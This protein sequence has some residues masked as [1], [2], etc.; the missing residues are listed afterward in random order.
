MSK[1]VKPTSES[2]INHAKENDHVKENDHM[3]ESDRSLKEKLQDLE[4]YIA[5]DGFTSSV[6]SKLPAYSSARVKP[7]SYQIWLPLFAS[8]IGSAFAAGNLFF[9]S[10]LSSLYSNAL[11]AIGLPFVKWSNVFTM[12]LEKLTS[13]LTSLSFSPLVTPLVTPIS[14]P[15]VTSMSF[16]VILLLGWL[17]IVLI[18]GLVLVKSR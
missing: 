7:Q 11:F 2:Y 10:S 13:S 16:N 6:L 15:L 12:N 9:N 17:F 14:T 3:L 1:P 18:S 4:F 5:D 8:L